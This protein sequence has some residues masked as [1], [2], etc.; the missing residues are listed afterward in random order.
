MRSE[1]TDRQL[2]KLLNDVEES[3]REEAVKAKPSRLPKT[4]LPRPTHFP[5]MRLQ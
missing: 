3:C 2:A 4:N 5:S 1:P